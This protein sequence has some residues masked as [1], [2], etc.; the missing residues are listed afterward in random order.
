MKN[1]KTRTLKLFP[2]LYVKFA[3]AAQ[4]K[5]ERH[6]WY[7]SERHVVFYT[8]EQKAFSDGE[9]KNVAKTKILLTQR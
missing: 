6:F 9:N 7:V 5:L 4:E 3:N 2:P 1:T 8:I